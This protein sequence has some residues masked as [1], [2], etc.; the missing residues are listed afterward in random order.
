MILGTSKS[1]S[2][3]GPGD[4]LTI[5]KMAQRIQEKY[6][7]IFNKYFVDVRVS[8]NLNC[9]ELFGRQT[10]HFCFPTNMFGVVGK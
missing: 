9:F 3:S 6:G 1:W 4:L 5:T 10:H 2:K 8:G 7:I